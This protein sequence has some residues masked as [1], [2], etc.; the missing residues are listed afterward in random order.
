MT[1]YF[2]DF[3]FIDDGRTIESLSIGMVADDGREFYAVFADADWQRV[4]QHPWLMANVVPSMLDE[5]TLARA[6]WQAVRLCHPDVNHPAVQSRATVVAGL[7]QFFLDGTKPGDQYPVELYA[8]YCA[9]DHVALAQLWGP[10]VNLPSFMPMWTNDLRSE[11]HRLGN[12]AVPRQ[13]Y[14]EHNALADARHNRVIHD[15]LASHEEG[16]ARE[17]ITHIQDGGEMG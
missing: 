11:C 9:Y 13:Q 12:P 16:L 3:E 8:W 7:E 14:D 15:F 4:S 17:L 6:P 2:Y 5:G 10:M 1:K